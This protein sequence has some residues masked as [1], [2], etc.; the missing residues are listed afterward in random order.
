MTPMA[1]QII[2]KE[3][4]STYHHWE[5][6]AFEP[7]P[8]APMPES[9]LSEKGDEEPGS[10][11]PRCPCPPSIKSNEFISRRRKKGTRRDTRPAG[12]MV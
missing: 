11:T 1:N 10:S 3:Q 6:D 12:R 8:V 7:P 4:F 5:M 2:P 9:P